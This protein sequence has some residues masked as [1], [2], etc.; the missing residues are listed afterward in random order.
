MPEVDD[1]MNGFQ[2]QNNMNV[3][4]YLITT[5]NIQHN[6]IV[7]Y[8]EYVYPTYIIAQ[9]NKN[10]NPTIKDVENFYNNFKSIIIKPRIIYTPSGRPYICYFQWP[11]NSYP[12]VKYTSDFRTVY[13]NYNGYAKRVSKAVADNFKF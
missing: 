3:G 10:S 1:Y 6:S 5:L 9:Y 7:R 12:D 4:D 13:L 11:E 2:I 8:N